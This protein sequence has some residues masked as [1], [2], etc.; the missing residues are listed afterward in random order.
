MYILNITKT[1]KTML[2]NEIKDFFFENYYKRI[3]FSKIIS[4][5][6]MQHLT[7]KDLLSPANKL[8][9]NIP[10]PRNVKE[11]YQSF[12]IKKNSITIRH[13]YLSTKNVSKPKH[14]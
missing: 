5:I 9:K 14:Y 10:D 13:N 7:K 12:V 3:G 4:H 8:I 2:V 6:S 1:I 11:H